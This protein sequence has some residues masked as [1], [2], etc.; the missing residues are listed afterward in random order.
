LPAKPRADSVPRTQQDTTQLVPAKRPRHRRDGSLQSR[1]NNCTVII[2]TREQLPYEFPEGIKTTVGTLATGDYS[3]AG[4]TPFVSVERKS[5]SDFYGCLIN[6]PNAKRPQ[7]NRDRFEAELQRLSEMPF[8]AVVVEAADADL[9]KPY[10]YRGKNGR[11]CVSQ[12]PPRV[13]QKTVIAWQW[14]YRIPIRFAGNGELSRAANGNLL[15]GLGPKGSPD[16]GRDEGYW[17]RAR[18]SAMKLTFL[19]LDDAVRQLLREQREK[20]RA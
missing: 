1:L 13:A 2:D 20:D 9:S 15:R 18:E 4:W 11:I 19:L 10:F 7:F 3:V 16:D 8:S 17:A 12:V 5:W 6:R 14:R